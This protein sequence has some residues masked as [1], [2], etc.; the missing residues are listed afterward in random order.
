VD[1]QRG[2]LCVVDTALQIVLASA[3]H[4]PF[5]RGDAYGAIWCVST[6]VVLCVYSVC[7]VWVH[8]L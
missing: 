2:I 6:V 7:I 5:G 8:C 1:L 3:T 4:H